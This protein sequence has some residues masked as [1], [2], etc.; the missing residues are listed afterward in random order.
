MTRPQDF[1]DTATAARLLGIPER[2]IA[3]WR[4]AK[5]VRRNASLVSLLDCQ[6]MRDRKPHEPD[7][8]L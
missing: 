6:K 3:K 7:P 4:D 1:V 2:T 8:P 5:R